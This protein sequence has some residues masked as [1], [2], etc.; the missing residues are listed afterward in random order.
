MTEARPR[1]RIAAVVVALGIAGATACTDGGSGTGSTEAT[2]AATEAAPTAA[3]DFA[4]VTAR[5]EA[6][7]ASGELPGVGLVIVDDD[8][9]LYEEAF[10]TSAVSSE[11]RIASATKLTSASII[12]TVVDDDLV[13]LDDRIAEYL[14]EFTDSEGGV[15]IRQ[16]L[17]QTHGLPF[18][19]PSIPLPGMESDLTMEQ[20]VEQIARDI[21]PV[22]APGTAF[23]YSPEIAYQIVGRI[24]EVA[25][26]ESW[27]EIF[28]TRIADPLDMPHTTYNEDENPRLGGGISTTLADYAHLLQMH[29]AR[30]TFRGERVLSERA[31]GEMQADQVEGLPFITRAAKPEVGYGLAWWFDEVEPGGEPIQISVA[32]YWGSIPWIDLSRGYGAFLLTFDR[33]PNSVPVW[34]EVVPLIRAALDS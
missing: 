12:M 14:P 21:A 11:L 20:A 24:A 4:A 17:S 3:P 32:G 23:E 10:G 16:L 27:S 13:D 25:T 15:T 8:E 31:V 33:L 6:A 5:L 29:L 18:N 30:G 26:G 22:R 34:E 28:E 19:H 9:I 7:V 2:T 1:L